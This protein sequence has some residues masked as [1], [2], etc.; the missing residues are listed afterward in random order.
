MISWFR[1]SDVVDVIQWAIRLAMLFI[2]PSRRTP[3][4]AR[5]WLLL[6]FFLP[7]PG[8][9]LFLLIG[10]PRFPTWRERHRPGP[11]FRWDCLP[12][13]RKAAGLPR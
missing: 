1:D 8:L 6:I 12:I 9:I 7:I 3:E 10:S 5:S 2:V 11:S 13:L 4:A